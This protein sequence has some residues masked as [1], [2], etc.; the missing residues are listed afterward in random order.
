LFEPP[1]LLV[2]RT[3]GHGAHTLSKAAQR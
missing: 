2:A 3:S 1:G